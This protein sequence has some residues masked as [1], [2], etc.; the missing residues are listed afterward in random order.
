MKVSND[1]YPTRVAEPTRTGMFADGIA[2]GV[3]WLD[4]SRNF[5][6]YAIMRAV[7]PREISRLLQRELNAEIIGE[8][9]TVYDLRII[10]QASFPRGDL[11]PDELSGLK[12]D[13]LRVLL[14]W[15]TVVREKVVSGDLD[16]R[17][18]EQV[19]EP[20]ETFAVTLLRD[21]ADELGSEQQVSQLVAAIPDDQ[22]RFQSRKRA[23]LREWRRYQSDGWE[24][25]Y[26]GSV[27]MGKQLMNYV[28]QDGIWNLA[29]ERQRSDRFLD[30]ATQLTWDQLE[31]GLPVAGSEADRRRQQLWASVFSPRQKEFY[32]NR[33]SLVGNNWTSDHEKAVRD[34]RVRYAGAANE[35]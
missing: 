14:K 32:G 1:F 17:F 23:L 6:E 28:L 3:F 24:K 18:L 13:A 16:L 19:A 33:G 9:I 2:A 22:L 11:S 20:A 21:R 15:S 27:Y 30:E 35:E 25:E 29:F 26:A 34:L 5:N 31:H 7:D 10:F 12:R 8:E 4:F